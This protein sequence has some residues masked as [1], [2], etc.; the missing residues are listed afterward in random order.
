MPRDAGTPA[1][2][3]AAWVYL[4]YLTSLNFT[5]CLAFQVLAAR[6]PTKK[7]LPGKPALRL[8]RSLLCWNPACR[9]TAEAALRHAY[10]TVD[11][12]KQEHYACPGGVK[13]GSWRGTGKLPPLGWC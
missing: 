6:D 13:A 5:R 8:L 10:F 11:L 9:P 7:G 3:C 4:L 1:V 2:L 12:Q